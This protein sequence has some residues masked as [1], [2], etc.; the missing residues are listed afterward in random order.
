M[1]N[2]DAPLGGDLAPNPT[3]R[4]QFACSVIDSSEELRKVQWD[5]IDIH[6]NNKRYETSK[7]VVI[8]EIVSLL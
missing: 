7:E 6:R 2:L 3:T 1:R 4:L 8:N 5:S